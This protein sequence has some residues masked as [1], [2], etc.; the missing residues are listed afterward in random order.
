MHRSALAGHR[1]AAAATAAAARPA[2]AQQ[3]SRPL[4]TKATPNPNPRPGPSPL[5]NAHLKKE[6]QDRT[7]LPEPVQDPE[8]KPASEGEAELAPEEEKEEVPDFLIVRNLSDEFVDRLHESI[9]KDHPDADRETVVSI[10][11]HTIVEHHQNGLMVNPTII[12][13]ERPDP[14][15]LLDKSAPVGKAKAG[16]KGKAKPPVRAT[17]PLSLEDD[18][19]PPL[20]A[21]VR[22]VN[23]SADELFPSKELIRQWKLRPAPKLDVDARTIQRMLD[24]V[25]PALDGRNTAETVEE[26]GPGGMLMT[27]TKLRS[28]CRDFRQWALVAQVLHAAHPLNIQRA[29]FLYELARAMGDYNA[30]FAVACLYLKEKSPKKR[31]EAEEL[32][33]AL[34]AKGHPHAQMRL[35]AIYVQREEY[36]K[37]VELFVT[38]GKNG[39]LVGF[40]EAGRLLMKQNDYAAAK[41][42]L[43]EASSRGEPRGD[44]YLAMLAKAQDEPGHVVVAHTRKAAEAGI[45]EAQHNLAFMY[46]NGYKG[47]VKPNRDL[48]IT[49]F[50]LADS[51]GYLPSTF[52]LGLL[53]GA[54]GD[55]KL[56]KKHFEKCAKA[57]GEFGAL[58]R[59][60][61]EK[62]ERGESYWSDKIT[63]TVPRKKKSDGW[64]TIM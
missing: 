38:S 63:P 62:L 23:V 51:H 14:S 16:A 10:V 30:E 8:S 21:P 20:D 52:N 34:S 3:L 29:Y 7:K 4:A 13:T 35:G 57:S 42:H 43:T 1:A 19:L 6:N 15:S 5:P 54:R 45:I 31:K 48:A 9:Q 18:E 17:K 50:N 41:Q 12:Y 60:E 22:M 26:L 40:V 28:A 24:V 25:D 27:A 33:V 53:A 37:A 56:A 59:R 36:K 49:W 32:F 61:L 39:N 64:C 58:A 47:G 11:A 46:L 55:T 2:V 44:Y